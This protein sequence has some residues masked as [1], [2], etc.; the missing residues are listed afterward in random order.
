[1]TD[2]LLLCT[3]CMM[4]KEKQFGHL[5]QVILKNR[6]CKA[7]DFGQLPLLGRWDR[8]LHETLKIESMVDHGQTLNWHQLP[9]KPDLK[10]LRYWQIQPLEQKLKVTHSY[11]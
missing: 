11:Q 6:T 9:R 3:L 5:Y 1:M 8:T 7:R 4:G 10:L 2:L